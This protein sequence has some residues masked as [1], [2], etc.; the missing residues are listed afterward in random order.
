MYKITAELRKKL[1]KPLGKILK[2]ADL[3]KIR[4][5]GKKIT[6]IGDRTAITFIK[7]GI[8][9]DIYVYDCKEKRKRIHEKDLKILDMIPY[10]KIEIKNKRGTIQEEIWA[11]FE[12]AKKRKTKIRVSGEE[13]LLAIPAIIMLDGTVYYG[14]AG[15]GIIEVA[16]TKK[17]KKDAE[18]ILEQMKV[19]V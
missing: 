15:K 6:A 7:E 18:K 8:F 17:T 16:I 1:K 9:P 19:I 11:V 14:Q 12:E 10:E 4:K 3:R 2:D 13:D 5:N